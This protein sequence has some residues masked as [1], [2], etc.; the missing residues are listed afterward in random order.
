MLEASEG[1]DDVHIKASA[2]NALDDDEDSA[3]ESIESFE[4]RVNAFV[5]LQLLRA[6]GSKRDEYKSSLVFQ[7]RKDLILNFQK[8]SMVKKCQNP[9]CGA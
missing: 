2:K 9:E 5:R 7:A 1:L 3:E 8:N 6:S 4:K